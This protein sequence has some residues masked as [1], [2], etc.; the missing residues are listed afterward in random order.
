MISKL[1]TLRSISVG[2]A[3]RVV[4]DAFMRSAKDADDVGVCG[5]FGYYT[6]NSL[7]LVMLYQ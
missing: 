7:F 3:M 6:S 5:L 1:I 2:V 4:P